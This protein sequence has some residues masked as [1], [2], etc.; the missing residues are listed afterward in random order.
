MTE[1]IDAPG[2][3]SGAQSSISVGLSGDEVPPVTGLRGWAKSMVERNV[4]TRFI[5]FL[6]IANAVTLGVATYGNLPPEVY[7]AFRQFDFFVVVVFI[8]EIGLKLIAYG[9]RF[10]K[11][12]WNVFDL[13]VVGVVFVPSSISGFAVLRALRVLR[14]LRL[15]SIVPMMRKIVEALFRAVPG[16]GAILAVLALITYVGAVM[17]TTMFSES[18]PELFGDLPLSALTLFQVMTMDGWRMEVLQ[19]V[20]D[21]GN[22]YAWIFFL[23]FIAVASFAVLNLFIALIVEA[24]SDDVEDAIDE[25]TEDV[26][27]NQ[28]LTRRE[29]QKLSEDVAIMRANVLELKQI[30]QQEPPENS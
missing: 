1:A 17:A 27:D 21:A 25:A 10:F 6:I 11:N 19:P 3:P 7:E 5:T 14:I 8:I 2:K 12:G 15:I 13:V 24:M 22:P 26:L 23:A 30:L 4:F 16:M 18:N 29:L 9:W 20:M 28:E